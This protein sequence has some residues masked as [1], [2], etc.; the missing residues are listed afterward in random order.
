M[1]L[2]RTIIVFLFLGLSSLA[3]SAPHRINIQHWTTPNGV[4]VY[5]V[6][7]PELPM[8]DIQVV[9]SAGSS[10]DGQQSGLAQLT[11]SMLGEG[12]QTLNADQVAATFESVGAVVGMQVN[13][14]MS[15]ASLRTTTFPENLK[16]ALQTFAQILSAPAF[17]KVGFQ[18]KQQQQLVSLKQQEQDPGSLASIALYKAI[19]GTHPY[20]QPGL[21]TPQSVTAL[22][23]EDARSF[24]NQY[25]VAQNAIITLVGAIDRK[26]AES[27]AADLSQALKS[28]KT[29]PALPKPSVTPV[30]TVQIPYPSTQK[31]IR[32][33]QIGMDIHDPDFFALA[34]GN[35]I[36]GGSALVSRLFKEV[37]E[38]RGLSYGVSSQFEPLAVAGPFAISLA[39]KVDQAPVALKVVQDVLQNFVKEGPTK[40]EMN[41]AKQDMI[42]G[43]VL[44]LSGNSA[45]SN[46]LGTIGF[47]QLPLDYLDTYTQRVQ[48]VTLE[49]V[50]DAFQRRIKPADLAI[51]LVGPA[52]S[53][54]KKP[55]SQ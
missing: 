36:L 24:F 53:D 11:N 51:V 47:Y 9:F 7:A 19:Y 44:R 55:V 54:A 41:S 32:L 30:T 26:Q 1:K 28:G 34:V 43:F 10:R 39:T 2:V 13:R 14:D 16:T 22:T 31:Q 29:A 48:A 8:L 3:H 42:N 33:G 23:Q 5:F 21:G 15:A 18:R 46:L 50:R 20:G 35:R 37:R 27:I 6:P 45:I 25:Y 4:R 49:Q 38:K 12:T 17:P 40:E 52:K